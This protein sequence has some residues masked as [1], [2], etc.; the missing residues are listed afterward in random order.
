MKRLRVGIVELLAHSVLTPRLRSQVI[1]PGTASMMPQAIAVWAQEAGCRVDY[2][3]WTAREPLL[4]LVPD[5]VDLVFISAFTRASFMAYALSAFLRRRGVIT[6]L[7]GP[8]AVSFAEHARDHFDYICQVTDRPLIEDLLRAPGR[9]ARGV[10]LSA[11]AGPTELPG[12][13]ERAPFIDHCIQGGTRL[14]RVVPMLGSTGCPYTCSFCVDAPT[15]WRA[16]EPEALRADLQEVERRWGPDTLVGWHDPNFAVR[17]PEYLDAIDGS[18]THLVHGAHMSLSLLTP[19]NIK[20]LS[21]A[22]FSLLAPGIESWFEFSDKS[23]RAHLLGEAK[24]RH[25]AAVLNEVQ[26]HV[27]HVQANLIV[28]L[29]SDRGDL[30]WE[31]TRRL[32]ERAPGIYPTFFLATNFYNAPLCRDL[33]ASGRTLAMPFPL[34]DT[35]TFGNVRPLHY[36]TPELYDRLIALYE[37]AYSW[38]AVLRRTRAAA[39]RWGKVINLSRSIDEGRGFIAAHRELRRS[40][41]T[42]RE[43]RAFYDGDR[44][45]PPA[46]FMR[47]VRD[48]LGPYAALLPS[49]LLTPDGYQRTFR[50]AA[51]AAVRHLRDAVAG[52]AARAV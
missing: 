37:S 33:H 40:L 36:S 20:R 23:G 49:T 34:L 15:P 11:N 1:A 13:Q 50:A 21:R 41:D 10:V 30:P 14:L 31:L 38:P 3:I 28:G 52:T 12:V 22:R 26:P 6:V 19:P 46:A 18:R 27:Q 47:T 5:D 25:V 4:T 17:F 48:H 44:A 43:L 16:F 7:G 2:A 45:A 35:N 39:G 29:D 8:H 51:D 42:D 24:L 32:A 9:Q